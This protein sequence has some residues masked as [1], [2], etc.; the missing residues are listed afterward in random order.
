MTVMLLREEEGEVSGELGAFW[1]FLMFCVLIPVTCA[2][3][4]HFVTSD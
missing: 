3:T 2:W 1:R 4:V